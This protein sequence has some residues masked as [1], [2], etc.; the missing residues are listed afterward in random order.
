[1]EHCIVLDLTPIWLCLC[2]FYK[3]FAHN[4]SF[5]YDATKDE[6]TDYNKNIYIF[7]QIKK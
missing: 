4:L 2:S 5:I 3:Y 6:A 1:M 7:K